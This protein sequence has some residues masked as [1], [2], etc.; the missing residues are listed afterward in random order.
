MV[1]LVG[2]SFG[3]ASTSARA[4]TLT[5]N[6][7][8]LVPGGSVGA[9][10]TEGGLTFTSPTA[11]GVVTG[12][13]GAVLFGW[14]GYTYVGNALFAHNTG[15][16]GITAGGGA[17]ASVSFKYG[18]DWNGYAI[19]YGLM[20]TTFGWQALSGGAVVASGAQTWNSRQPGG[21][22]HG[23]GVMSVTPGLAF[24]TLLVRS[25]ATAYQAIPG[26]GSWFYDRGAVIGYGDENHI[27]F[28]NVSVVTVPDRGSSG[29]LLS[30]AVLALSRVRRLRP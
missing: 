17:M 29:I 10:Y 25:T 9:P 4:T 18:F 7:D 30:L 12:S 3:F 19:E 20:D 2:A 15:W 27:A 5:A 6:F 13:F 11:F 23:G 24:D 14:G 8:S 28:D 1:A 16:V 26:T 22:Y 21:A